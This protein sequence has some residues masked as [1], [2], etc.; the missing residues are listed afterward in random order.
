MRS[1]DI[2]RGVDVLATRPEVDRSAIRGYARGVKGFWLLLAAAADPRLTRLWL[3]RTPAS[4]RAAFEG[5]MTNHLFDAMIPGFARH[6]DFSDLLKAIG[7]RPV[8]WTDPTDWM[9]Q[10]VE[11]G[12]QFRYRYVG[13]SD[14][15]Y[16]QEFLR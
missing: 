7:N 4:L 5:P 8:L 10:V 9:N 15:A 13:E 1:H 6:W 3:D 16:V 14:V 12:P 2:L 11:A